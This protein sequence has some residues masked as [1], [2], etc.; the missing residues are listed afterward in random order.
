[1]AKGDVA[2]ATMSGRTEVRRLDL[3]S[4]DSIK[5]FADAWD[6]PLD[7]LINNAGVM[8]PPLSQTRE[9]FELQ[10]GANHLGHFALTNLLLEH[11]TGRAVTLP[12]PAHKT[13]R[14]DFEDLNWERKPYRASRAYGQSKLA[15][16]LFTSELQRRLSR[17]GSSVKATAAHPGYAAT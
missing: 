7:L 5:G 10:F 2:A 12:S 14:I 8:I 15:N 4:L 17:A 11:A 3:A 1:T 16:L 6:E 13:G 9:G